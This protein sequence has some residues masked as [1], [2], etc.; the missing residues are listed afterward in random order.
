MKLFENQRFETS[1]SEYFL[2]SREELFLQIY[3]IRTG[4]FF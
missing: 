1:L 4:T 2:A 3:K